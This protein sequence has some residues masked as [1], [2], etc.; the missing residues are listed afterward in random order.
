M[1]FL[2]AS[3]HACSRQNV[4]FILVMNFYFMPLMGD[5]VDN[6]DLIRSTKVKL[7]DYQELMHTRT[8]KKKKNLNFKHKA[9]FESDLM[10]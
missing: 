4:I 1:D 8:K 10:I 9:N 7:V 5:F 2:V 3:L 6:A